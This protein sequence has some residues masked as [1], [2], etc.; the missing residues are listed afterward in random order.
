MEW[1]VITPKGKQSFPRRRGAIVHGLSLSGRERDV[2]D[3]IVSWG[4]G[5]DYEY[6]HRATAQVRGLDDP[7]GVDFMTWSDGR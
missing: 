1:V 7:L 5:Y 3:V 4:P 6:A 2:A